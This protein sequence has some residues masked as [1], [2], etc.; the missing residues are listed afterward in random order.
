MKKILLPALSLLL[1][2][3]AVAGPP[4]VTDDPVPTDANHWE[5][6]AFATG[7]QTSGNFDG[8]TG[9]DL[10]YGPIEDVQLTATLPV[11]FTRGG[12]DRSGIG[13]VELGI[14]YRFFHKEARGV[15]I[16]IFPR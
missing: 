16:A 11:S 1:P 12:A 3:I 2:A 8:D 9:L 6:Y 13:D 7:T 10:N 14:K 4:Y 5:I 15:A